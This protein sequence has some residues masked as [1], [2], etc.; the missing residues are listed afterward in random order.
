M[1]AGLCVQEQTSSRGPWDEACWAPGG[2]G[3]KLGMLSGSYVKQHM[4]IRGPWDEATYGGRA[5]C[6]EAHEQ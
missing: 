1:V 2:H 4:S 6:A 5:M 3:M